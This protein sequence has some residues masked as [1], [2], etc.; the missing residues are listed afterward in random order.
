MKKCLTIINGKVYLSYKPLRISESLIVAGGRVIFTGSKSSALT[1]SELLEC[2]LIDLEGKVVLPGFIDAH[3]HLDGIGMYL[4]T[5][6]LRGVKSIEELKD[7]VRRFVNR[8]SSWIYGHGWDQELFVEGRWPTRWDIDE[9]VSDKPVLLTRICGHA[10]VLNTKAMEV[11]GLISSDSPHVLRNEKGEVT[12]VIKEEALEIA[13]KKFRESLT[14]DDHK[15]FLEDAVK[16]AA[17][18]GVTTVGFVSV[19]ESTLKILE[20]LRSEGKLL[21][22]VRTYLNPGKDNEVL[23]TLRKLGIRSGFGD[24]YLKIH[25]IKVFVDGSLGAR[26]A[27]LTQPYNDALDTYGSQ[28]ID[29]KTLEEL[30]KEVHESGLQLAIHAIGDAA[31]DLVLHVYSRIRNL[32]NSRHRIEHASVIR[33]DQISKAKDL[34]I[35]LVIQPHFIITD[36]WVLKRLGVSRATYVYPFKTLINSGI[37]LGISTDSPVEPLN[38]WETVYAAVTRGEY[39]EVE[40]SKHTPQEKLSLTDTLHSYTYGSAYALREENNIGTLEVGKFADFIIVDKDPYAVDEKTLRE[41][42]VLATYVGGVKVYGGTGISIS[43]DRGAIT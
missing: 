11:T 19:N 13:K 8:A 24:D 23:Q 2:D 27:W 37:L 4:N 7:K 28:L 14:M 39:E 20:E 25:G 38:P 22:R 10:A 32:S 41:I 6:D 36:W 26:T 21:I 34:G 35:P 40:L 17:S 12:G 42:K 29:E 30:V 18:L 15:K 43:R 3:L 31:I 5:I 1:I 33:P 16:Y 9:V